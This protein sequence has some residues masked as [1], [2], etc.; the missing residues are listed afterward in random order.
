MRKIAIVVFS[1][2]PH[3]L[4]IRRAAEAAIKSDYYVDLYCLRGQGQGEVEHIHGGTI[5]RLNVLRTRSLR[6]NYMIEY[7]SFLVAVFFRLSRNHFRAN[8][9]VI[10]VNNMPDFLVFAGFLAKITGA[11]IILDMH[12]PMPEVFMTK[13][14]VTHRSLFVRLLVS[15]E[16]MSIRFS[17]HIIT[18]NIAFRELFVKRGCPPGKID[19]VMNAP[20]DE[21]FAMS[22]LSAA[23]QRTAKN[24]FQV[25]FNGTIVD[26]H[27]LDDAVD[28]IIKLKEKIPDIKF[29]I[30]G[31]GDA[32]EK[33]CDRI[34]ALNVQ[35]Y[36]N[37]HGFVHVDELVKIIE[38][39]DVGIIPNIRSPF[40]ELNFPVRIFE[41][42]IFKKPIIAPNTRGIRDYFT[43]DSLLMFDPGNSKDLAEKIYFVF[44]NPEET[45]EIIRKGY[46]VYEKHCWRIQRATL[47]G[48]Y[49]RLSRNN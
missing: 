42:L 43:R 31:E 40:T 21:I 12:D 26:R 35:S 4:R 34:R 5:F 32:A 37:Y 48:I 16:R 33:L 19:I 25:V 2:Y 36:I 8:Y 20:D 27:G 24:A 18:T 39:A 6:I 44:T 7:V 22:S 11:R 14:G 28:A 23:P 49:D 30:Y 29:D 3:D 41:Y 13:Y 47:V 15:Q 38:N 46:D 10:H 9:R 17:D 1:Y 45:S